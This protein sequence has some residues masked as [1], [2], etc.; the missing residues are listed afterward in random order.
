MVLG[1]VFP[2]YGIPYEVR[3]SLYF[4]P[5]YSP[6]ADLF[7]LQQMYNRAFNAEVE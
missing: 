4:D 3:D 6:G 1:L 7:S 5:S 2:S